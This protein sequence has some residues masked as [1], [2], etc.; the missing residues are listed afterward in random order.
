MRIMKRWKWLAL[1]AVVT[2]LAVGGCGKKQDEAPAADDS[3]GAAAQPSPSV[4][5]DVK[6]T[7]TEAVEEAQKAAE[8]VMEEATGA[9]EDAVAK[10]KELL[11]Q[12][13]E[14][15]ADRDLDSVEPIIEKLKE[16][17]DSLPDELRKQIEN[18]EKTF[19]IAKASSGKIDIP[20]ENPFKK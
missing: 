15:L 4:M 2:A 1:L 12:A 7:A 9:A 5:D 17:K 10:A 6:E 11:D 16:L 18:L 19:G 20:K 3:T 8:A 14:Y 13:R